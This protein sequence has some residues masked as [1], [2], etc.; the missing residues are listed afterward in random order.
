MY[1]WQHVHE[2]SLNHKLSVLIHTSARKYVIN[3]IQINSTDSLLVRT[4]SSLEQK[5]P[6]QGDQSN[7]KCFSLARSLEFQPLKS[8]SN[9][10]QR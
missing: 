4:N 7:K 6:L 9:S 1:E 10:G 2:T 5:S 3:V 8:I